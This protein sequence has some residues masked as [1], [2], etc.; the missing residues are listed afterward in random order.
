MISNFNVDFHGTSYPCFYITDRSR[1][2][3]VIDQLMKKQGILAADL[4][5]AAFPQWAHYNEAALSPFLARPRLIQMFTGTGAVVMDLFKIGQIDL[6]RIFHSRPSVFHNMTFDYKMLRRHHAV[7]SPDM[8]CTAIMARCVLHALYPDDRR[9]DLRSVV[10]WLFKEDINKKAGA[11]DWSMQDLTYEQV[12]YAAKD[13]IMQMEVYKKL[14]D[15]I[16]KLKLRKAYDVY[17]K[18]QLAISEM[19]LNG[20]LIDD[21]LHRQNIVRWREELK[22]A[23]DEVLNLTGL[24]RITD[25]ILSDWLEKSLDR[26]TLA[27]WPRTEKDERLAT[28]AHT[29]SD[30]SYLAI[31]KPF[32]RYQKLK[33]LTTSFGMRLLSQINPETKKLHPGYRVAGAKTGRLSCASPNLQQSP[34]DKS[35]RSVFISS[36]GYQ[37]VVAD[38]SAIEVRYIAELSQEERLLSTFEKGLDVYKATV[39]GILNKKY[40]D[41]TKEERQIGKSLVLG[42][43]YGLGAKKF[44][45]YAHKGYGVEISQEEAT[46][47]VSGYRTLYPALR[48][49]QLDQVNLCPLRRYT[50][51]EVLGKSRKLTEDNYYGACLNMPVQGGC[52][53][54]MLLA[55]VKCSELF[56]EYTSARLLASVH[57][58]IIA[59]ALPHEVDKIKMCLT[60]GMVNAYKELVPNARTLK[61][62]VD[63][64]HGDNWANAK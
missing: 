41:V 18:A 38:Y 3:S 22:D 17:R 37:L 24:K 4:E 9:A 15:F 43:S 62:L 44:S 54:M 5:T 42:L 59:E 25:S 14:D 52:A 6:S 2:N 46:G 35:F 49:W 33:K 63:P 31:V 53:S 61:N 40:E 8:H 20:L 16:E 45:H 34:R 26:E 48:A 30:F 28:D 23:S 58:E 60:T 36:P 47:L 57:D 55:L 27:I 51:F 64:S 7:V 19:E 32:S 29:F 56:K 10:Q 39:A 1:A 11:S 12:Y 13:A 50:A 21:K